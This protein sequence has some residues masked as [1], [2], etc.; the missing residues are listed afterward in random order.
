MTYTVSVFFKTQTNE[1]S[2]GRKY[3]PSI[4]QYSENAAAA[5]CVALYYKGTA[6]QVA[7]TVAKLVP[8][9]AT[10]QE[11]LLNRQFSAFVLVCCRIFPQS[12]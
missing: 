7:S 3:K 12:K 6:A 10:G 2:N 11:K 1:Y 5:G 4:T 9:L 8:V